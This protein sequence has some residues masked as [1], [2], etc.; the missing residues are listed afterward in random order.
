MIRNTDSFSITNFLV[1]KQQLLC[2]ANQ[3]SSCCFLDTHQYHSANNSVECLVGVGAIS[4]FTQQSNNQQQ[5]DDYLESVND[6]L[7]GHI[8]Y[9]YI[10]SNISQQSSLQAADKIG[11]APILF[12]QPSI[13]IHLSLDSITIESATIS[14]KIVFQ[15][16][17][18]TSITIES[19]LQNSKLS[20]TINP[21]ISKA[22]YIETIKQ[23]QLHIK[24]GDCYEI[25]FCQQFAASNVSINPVEKYQQL[26]ALSPN[27]FACFYKQD[28]S[29]LLCASPERFL[30]KTGSQLISQPIKGTIQRDKRNP[31]IDEQLKQQLYHSTTDRSENVMVVDLVRNDLSRICQAATVQ[32]EELFGIYSYPQVH[33]MISTLV[34]QVKP[35]IGFGA[36]LDATF[37]MGSMTGAPKRKVME[38]IHQYEANKRGLFSGAV[39]YISPNKDF[40]FN[41]VIRSILYNA[42]NQYLSYYV[43]SGITYY[44][45][46]EL[47][48]EECMLKA[49]A[50]IRVLGNY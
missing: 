5:L 8:C 28:E 33:Q 17:I 24:R 49:E 2:W 29:H 47:E 23:L 31:A 6:W 22:A 14:P 1:T 3:Y 9:E 4:S 25:N 44:S 34:G 37:P 13:V 19:H 43:G 20:F 30:K 42:A 16:I 26:T 41:V 50:I 18:E 32:V 10:G 38:L 48:Y 12:F 15:Q 11:F 27:P 36:I 45:N 35:E 40:D 46:P 21:Q 39:G 7:F